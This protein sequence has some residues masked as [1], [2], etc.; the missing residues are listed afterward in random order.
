MAVQTITLT[1]TGINTLTITNVT[2]TTPAGVEHSADFS[3]FKGG[4]IN[5]TGTVFTTTTTV[6]RGNSVQF[7]IDYFYQSGAT[8]IR[9]GSIVANCLGGASATINTEIKV[10]STGTAFYPATVD[11][12]HQVIP[13]GTIV[14]WSGSIANIPY[15]WTLCNGLNSTPDLRNRFIIAANTSTI[16]YR[17]TKLTASDGTSQD[18][19]GYSLDVT[20][21]GNYMIVG[22]YGEDVGPSGPYQVGAVYI[23]NRV[24]GQM[25]EQAKI[26]SPNVTE[27][28]VFGSDVAIN[29]DGTTAIIGAYGENTVGKAHIFTRSGSVWANQA[30]LTPSDGAADDDFGIA[31]DISSDGNT[32]IVG[33][34]LE[35]TGSPGNDNGAAY[36]FTRTAGVWS[37]Q[38]KLLASDA[39][40]SDRF[41]NAVILSSDGNTA[42]ISAQL[43]S[44]TP[45][46]QNGAV[47]VFTRAS[48][49]WTEQ[50]KLLASDA[51]T[52][53]RFG[54]ELSISPD[55]DT[56]LIGAGGDN[57][58]GAAYVFTRSAGVWTE[59][60]KITA[61]DSA[62]IDRFGDSVAINTTTD[63]AIIGAL[64]K[65]L[66]SEADVGAAYIFTK[67]GGVWS[68]QTKLLPSDQVANVDFGTSVAVVNTTTFFVGAPEISTGI[69]YQFNSELVL[70]TSV[71][72]S[73]T[74]TGGSKDQVLVTHDHTINDPG[75]THVLEAS[76]G[77]GGGGGYTQFTGASPGSFSTQNAFTDITVDNSGGDTGV[78]QNLP[79][80]FALAYIMK[81]TTAT[82][83]TIL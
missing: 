38:Q 18:Y 75:H 16:D 26:S 83:T 64:G 6:L 70:T 63:V 54:S 82:L 80:Y 2:F 50:Q 46:V 39:T 58:V 17:Q 59:Q 20:P 37:E 27:L 81:T 12:I 40:A 41:G 76:S 32:A 71:T 5:F 72:G 14:M 74:S 56:L 36:V 53:A 45:N 48:G 77:I 19:F 28:G 66:L 60:Q 44:T 69:V 35:D 52:G 15:G 34:Y 8:G 47:Y 7:D 43:E 21:D 1:N 73:A 11:Y 24:S 29:Q 78:N 55:G 30:T 23:F 9:T 49:V 33:S 65:D 68:Q 3:L 31:V 25:V 51:S 22:A 62:S 4:N 67:S 57:N 79:P 13:Y 10:Q 61:S 42:A